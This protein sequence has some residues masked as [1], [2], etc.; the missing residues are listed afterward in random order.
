MPA[1]KA[2]AHTI[3]SK[4][5]SGFDPVRDAEEKR[6]HVPR[7]TASCAQEDHAGGEAQG[8]E[9]GADAKFIVG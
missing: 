2:R 3:P 5:A 4:I 9:T 7:A 1:G 8:H 6:Q